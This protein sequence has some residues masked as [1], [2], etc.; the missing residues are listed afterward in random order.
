MARPAACSIFGN[1]AE[2]KFASSDFFIATISKMIEFERVKAVLEDGF[3]S[4][5]LMLGL[6]FMLGSLFG[7]ICM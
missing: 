3:D 6:R 1:Y 4:G 5:G 2:S 7:S